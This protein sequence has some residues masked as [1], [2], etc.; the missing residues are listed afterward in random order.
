M[1]LFQKIIKKNKIYKNILKYKNLILLLLISLIILL[2][3]NYYDIIIAKFTKKSLI[4]NITDKNHKDY[5]K[6]GNGLRNLVDENNNI[7]NVILIN[8]PFTEQ[9]KYDRY[10]EAKSRGVKFIGCSSYINFPCITQNKYDITKNKN[11]PSWKYNYFDLCFGWFHCFRNP[12]TCIPKNFPKALISESDF[13]RY[14]GYKYN[15]N[16][17]KEYDFIYIC[18]KDGEGT[19]IKISDKDKNKC[20]DG[21]QSENRNWELGKKCIKIMCEKYNMKGLLIGRENC[22]LPSKCHTLMDTTGFLK[23]NEFI[24]QYEKCRFIFVPNILDASPRVLTEALCFN[25][26]CLV[27]YNILGGWKYVND[28]TG[29][30]FNDENDFDKVLTEFRSKL[31]T[32]SPRDYFINNHGSKYEGKKIIEFIKKHVPN[33]KKEINLDLDKI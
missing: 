33:Y 20:E 26:P 22:E 31:D 24:K 23:Y 14:E 4:N 10:L 30:F 28:K 21:W 15:P 18:L 1:K 27:N 12:D 7:C 16:A 25:L 29:M 8:Y 19:N 32:Y 2:T 11:N 17:K 6:Y 5:Y 3:Y 9:K 13:S